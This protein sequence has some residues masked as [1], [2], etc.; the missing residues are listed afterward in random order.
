[1]A[2]LN[3]REYT[4]MAQVIGPAPLAMEP[5]LARQN[6]NIGGGSVASNPFNALTRYVRLN[7]DVSCRVEF[8]RSPVADLLLS[9]RCAANQTV[10]FSIPEGG[11]FSVAVIAS[12]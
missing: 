5:A 8:G 7:T 6:V 9:A 4:T 2:L 12:A 10:Y 11:G 1:M 3:V